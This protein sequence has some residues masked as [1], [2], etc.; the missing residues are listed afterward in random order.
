MKKET[1]EYLLNE[2]IKLLDDYRIDVGDLST[3]VF[4]I[5]AHGIMTCIES[6]PSRIEDLERYKDIFPSM[7]THIL[8]KK[9]QEWKE[10]DNEKT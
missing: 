1:L 9:I 7:L 6:D 5:L 4:N 10:Q 8:D 3:L 2:I